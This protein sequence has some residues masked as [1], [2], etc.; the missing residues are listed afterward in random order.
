MPK[1]GSCGPGRKA[2]TRDGEVCSVK[3]RSFR[4][5]LPC[6]GEDMPGPS[7]LA[8]RTRGRDG[9]RKNKAGKKGYIVKLFLNMQISTYKGI[10]WLKPTCRQEGAP[11]R[12]MHKDYTLNTC[13]QVNI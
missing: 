10:F 9:R 8:G 11:L 7:D 12:T 1:K 4:C 3:E 6:P 2:G 5:V 13:I